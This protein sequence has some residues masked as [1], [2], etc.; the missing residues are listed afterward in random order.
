MAEDPDSFTETTTTSWGGRIGQS[1]IGVFIGILL[2]PTAIVLLY[3]NEGRAV[4]AISAP[5]QG[6]RQVVEATPDIILAAND[7]T[8]VHLTGQ[9]S[10]A[11][12]ARDSARRGRRRWPLAALSQG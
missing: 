6:L 10:T 8:L 2:I 5:H 7:G 3:W 9:I 4:E 12:P 1:I 11:T